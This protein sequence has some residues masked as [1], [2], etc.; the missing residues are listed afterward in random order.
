[1]KHFIFNFIFLGVLILTSCS[2]NSSQKNNNEPE[3][4]RNFQSEEAEVVTKKEASKEV[5]PGQAVYKA[6]C[7][8][9]H[10]VDGSGVPGM[11]PP[12]WSEEWIGN[13][14]KM[15][16]VALTGLSGEVEVDGEIYN[17][18]MPP[19]NH[20]SDEELAHVL[21]YVR[22]SFGNDFAA[23]TKEEVAAAR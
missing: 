14:E 22:Q 1:M 10:Q 13:K 2:G 8:T 6:Y 16:S 7:S 17:N 18:L 4:G 5:H 20:L 15:I 21:S 11:Y 9:C 12:L 3:T 23:I 19:H